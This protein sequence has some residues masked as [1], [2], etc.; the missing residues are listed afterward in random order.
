MRNRWWLMT[1]SNHW[2]E[3]PIAEGKVDRSA[4]AVTLRIETQ[5]LRVI[6]PEA[7]VDSRAEIQR[8]MD[9][10]M[11]LDVEHFPQIAFESTDVESSGED[12][13]RVHGKLGLHGRKAPMIV[14]IALKNGHHLGSATINQKIYGRLALQAEASK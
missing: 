12:Q 3:A 9:S 2:I 11:V 6:D 7:S 5:K 4:N 10:P 8:T 13:W 14:D 1:T